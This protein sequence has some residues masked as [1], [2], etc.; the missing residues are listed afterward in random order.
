MN[1]TCKKQKKHEKICQE[2][3]KNQET[4]EHEEQQ[5]HVEQHESRSRPN[6][7]KPKT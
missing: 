7:N 6:M 3:D 4:Q 1:Q 2:T 5:E